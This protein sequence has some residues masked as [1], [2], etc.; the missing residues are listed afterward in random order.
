[1]CVWV[2]GGCAVVCVMCVWLCCVYAVCVWVCC[3]CVCVCVGCVCV[4]LL[5]PVHTYHGVMLQ[6][7]HILDSNLF[8]ESKEIKEK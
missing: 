3:V 5:A 4:C 2:C 6:V 7:L 1:M 8:M